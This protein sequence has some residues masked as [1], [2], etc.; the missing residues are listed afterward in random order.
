MKNLFIKSLL[1]LGAVFG[2]SFAVST[3]ALAE[4]KSVGQTA[5]PDLTGAFMVMNNKVPFNPAEIYALLPDGKII[6]LHLSKHL[7]Q[8]QRAQLKILFY[9]S[10]E[11]LKFSEPTHTTI[12]YALLENGNEFALYEQLCLTATQLEKFNRDLITVLTTGAQ[13]IV[14]DT[15]EKSYD[16]GYADSQSHSIAI[17]PQPPQFQ[18]PQSVHC[19]TGPSVGFKGETEINCY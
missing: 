7:T 2:I 1:V 3:S 9:C 11:W 15:A 4:T 12:E 14:K 16:A 18:L 10:Q 17:R 13:K 6:S 5:F 19:T 8:K